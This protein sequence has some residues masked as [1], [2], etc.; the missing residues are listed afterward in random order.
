MSIN[1]VT[2][3]GVGGK[4]LF[5]NSLQVFVLKSKKMGRG[6]QSPSSLALQPSKIK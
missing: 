6:G 1:D 5:E 2:A 4:G 3:L